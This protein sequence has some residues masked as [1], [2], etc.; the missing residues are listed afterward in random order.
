MVSDKLEPIE[1]KE[2]EERESE[3][4]SINWPGFDCVNHYNNY[5]KRIHIFSL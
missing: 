1:E 3:S 4:P 2:E 5:F